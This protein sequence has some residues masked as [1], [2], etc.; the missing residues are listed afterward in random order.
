MYT[1]QYNTRHPFQE[2]TISYFFCNLDVTYMYFETSV[3]VRKCTYIALYYKYRH[4]L[5][6]AI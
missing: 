3:R 4:V 1:V 2:N 6:L 5:L